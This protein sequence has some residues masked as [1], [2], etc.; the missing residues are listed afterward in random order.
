MKYKQLILRV[1][2]HGEIAYSPATF[3]DFGCKDNKA[4]VIAVLDGGQIV[5][6][7]SRE[8]LFVKNIT[9]CSRD[10]MEVTYL[11]GRK[12]ELKIYNGC[13]YD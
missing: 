3:C 1:D 11:D 13:R 12:A 4:T 6:H 7:N 10:T 8:S 9:T 2:R 5:E